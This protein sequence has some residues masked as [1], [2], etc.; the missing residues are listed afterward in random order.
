[1]EFR[2]KDEKLMYVRVNYRLLSSVVSF[3]QF[4]VH[5]GISIMYL[6]LKTTNNISVSIKYILFA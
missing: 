5:G 4:S 2:R 1:M 3:E 6:V